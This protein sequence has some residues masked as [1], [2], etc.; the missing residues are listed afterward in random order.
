MIKCSKCGY[1]NALGHIFC[2]QCRSKLNIQA[3]ADPAWHERKPKSKGARG[4]Q[5]VLFFLLVVVAGGV[6]LALWP[7]PPQ[8]P[9]GIA[10]DAQQADKKIALLEQNISPTTQVFSEREINAYLAMLLREL[11]ASQNSGLRTVAVAIRPQ[12]VVLTTIS[13][14]GPLTVGPLKLGPKNISTQVQAVPARGARGFQWTVTGG[15]I[16]HL[17]LPGPFSALATPAL[18]PL[19]AISVRERALLAA[20]TQLEL[21][22]GQATVAIKRA[23]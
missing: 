20:L 16:G 4:F 7:L 5:R 14:W 11:P 6:V 21:E 23:R 9:Q 1:E 19:L 2:T 3:V 8:A 12:A 13:A 15:K 22:E 18:R 10:T 17:P